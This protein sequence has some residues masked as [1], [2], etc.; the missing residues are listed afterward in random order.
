MQCRL[1]RSSKQPALLVFSA[2]KSIRG[3]GLPGSSSSSSPQPY[4]V[5]LKQSDDVRQD[6]LAMQT[7]RFMDR[8]LKG[9]GLD[10]Q[11]LTYEVLALGPREVRGLGMKCTVEQI[12]TV[13]PLC[14]APTSSPQFYLPLLNSTK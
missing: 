13:A 4:T 12:D 9:S 7:V 5:L 8:V 10:L 11:L 14:T 2:Y 1:L 6:E 3:L